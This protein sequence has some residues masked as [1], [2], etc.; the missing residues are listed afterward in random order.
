LD[1]PL[2]TYLL[3]VFAARHWSQE[4]ED[5]KVT[6]VPSGSVSSTCKFPK[7]K[8]MQQNRK[9][10]LLGIKSTL[11][12]PIAKRAVIFLIY[13]FL[14]LNI[15]LDTSGHLWTASVLVTLPGYRSRGPRFDSRHYQIF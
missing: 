2:N 5:S 3:G 9:I 10:G 14:V 15:I 12:K 4:P 8:A 11:L 13:I 1:F 6:F 7:S